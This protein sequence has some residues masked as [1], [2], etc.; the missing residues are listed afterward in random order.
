MVSATCLTTCLHAQRLHGPPLPQLPHSFLASA[1]S[2]RLP[3]LPYQ[4]PGSASL[5]ACTSFF[6]TAYPW[7][8][9]RPPASSI[10]ASLCCNCRIPLPHPSAASAFP[11][12]SPQTEPRHPLS[13]T[14]T[15]SRAS[16]YLQLPPHSI[17]MTL[18]L[19]LHKCLL[20]LSLSPT[21]TF[22]LRLPGPRH[23]PAYLGLFTRLP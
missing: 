18:R 9:P 15:P 7:N 8:L 6:A 23:A 12:A 20:Y 13:P 10:A 11:S 1:S 22:S 4:V 2:T 5:H 3:Q 16:A 19:R 21:S 17:S 14:S